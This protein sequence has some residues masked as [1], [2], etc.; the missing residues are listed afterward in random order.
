MAFERSNAQNLRAGA[1]VFAAI[2]LGACVLALA[3]WWDARSMVNYTVTCTLEQGVYGLHAGSPVRVGG[4]VRGHVTAVRPVLKDTT[5]VGYGVDITL[6]RSVVLYRAA[7]IHAT[8]TGIAGEGAVDIVD[9]GRGRSI[10]S[11]RPSQA[12]EAGVLKPGEE[13][14]SVSPLQ[15]QW[16]VGSGGAKTVG[17]VVRGS[18]R[19]CAA[20]CRHSSGRVHLAHAVGRDV[21]ARAASDRQHGRRQ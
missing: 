11:L 1:G 21:H 15:Y 3:Q 10:S 12:D 14:A 6:S 8:T 17:Q 20:Y 7:R 2:A 13:I 16:L 19:G 18:Q 4:L 9:T 5:L